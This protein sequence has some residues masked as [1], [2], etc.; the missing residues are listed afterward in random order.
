MKQIKQ[1]EYSLTATYRGG[2]LAVEWHK[3]DG[4]KGTWQGEKSK[5]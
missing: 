5:Q 1:A 4:G 2:T 3:L